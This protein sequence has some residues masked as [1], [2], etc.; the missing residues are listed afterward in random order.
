MSQIKVQEEVSDRMKSPRSN[1]GELSQTGNE[2]GD[3]KNLTFIRRTI[4]NFEDLT[5]AER[6]GLEDLDVNE[7]GKLQIDDLTSAVV[8]Q[9][10][11]NKRIVFLDRQNLIMAA[12]LA[13]SLLANGGML[14]M[15]IYAFKDTTTSDNGVLVTNNDDSK[16]VATA[17]ANDKTSLAA[18]LDFS[19][20]RLNSLEYV[21]INEHEVEVGIPVSGWQKYKKKAVQG[22]GQ[23]ETRCVLLH[24]QPASANSAL[25]ICAEGSSDPVVTRLDGAA[26]DAEI[27][28]YGHSGEVNG[29]RRLLV[30]EEDSECPYQYGGGGVYHDHET[31]K[32]KGHCPNGMCTMQMTT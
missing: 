25:T 1:T 23:E 32:L 31:R 2:K 7:K 19:S 15:I 11:T 5:P 28:T 20:D 3:N 26:L 30:V 22:Q 24:I 16:V 29:R 10:E 27:Q 13:L 14:A 18:V 4:L 8:R 6:R 17:K 12:V 9:K 21:T